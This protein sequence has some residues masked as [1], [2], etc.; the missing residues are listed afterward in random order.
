VQG[1][2]VKAFE[3]AFAA[4]VGVPH[5]VAVSNCTSALFLGLLA[6]NLGAGDKVAVCT[7]SWPATA[8]AICAVGAVPVFVDIEPVAFSMDPAALERELA[9]RSDIKAV[10]VV[11]PF[12]ASAN[13]EHLLRITERHQI[14]LIED[15][16]CALGTQ[17]HGRY[18]GSWGALGTFSFH[19]RKAVTTGEGGML[20]TSSA[21]IARAVT[22]LR[23]HG[24]D[25]D[26]AK[27][28]FVMFG[29]NLRMTDMQGALGSVQLR[30][31][32]RIIA[33]RMQAARRYDELLRSTCVSVP[34]R[35]ADT[36]HVY[37]SYVVLLPR[38]ARRSRDGVIAFMKERGIETTL[39]TYAMPLIRSF[40]AWGGFR[41]GDFPVTDDIA[42][43]AL[44][45][46]MYESLSES[47]QRIV[48]STLLE[49][50]EEPA[51][52]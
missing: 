3:E 2:R 24:Q 38:D 4:Y 33:A 22:M 46:P 32:E 50:L 10:V 26:A 51:H 41:P 49:A 16:A 52:A 25:P 40:Q 12:G 6:L 47:D 1:P 18:A 14:P 23:N 48:V 11:H 45:L 42:A 36:R 27:P 17:Q 29:H 43:R 21:R 31:V 35:L 15:A 7:Y 34:Q 30:K 19:P 5:A 9:R 44:T 28:E 13:T 37:Q 39:G 8:N 20:V